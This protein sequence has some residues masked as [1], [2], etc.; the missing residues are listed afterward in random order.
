MTTVVVESGDFLWGKQRRA[1]SPDQGISIPSLEVDLRRCVCQHWHVAGTKSG[2]E[3]TAEHAAI[4]RQLGAGGAL[5]FA[6]SR[7]ASASA[8]QWSG[9]NCSNWLIGVVAI[10]DNT[11][12]R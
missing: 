4:S 10:C 6:V 2:V 9:R 7:S 12:V 1:V 3:L 11:L 5:A 8:F